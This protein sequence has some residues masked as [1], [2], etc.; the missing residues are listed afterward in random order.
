MGFYYEQSP[1]P[2]DDDDDGERPGCLD[3]LVIIR[4]VFGVLLWPIAAIIIVL[5]DLALIFYFLTTSP[6]L[7]VI[8][9]ALTVLAFILLAR[10]EAAR[11]RPP[12]LGP[13]NPP[14]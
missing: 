9:V 7:A 5:L 4:I 14:S 8:P 2:G 10:W 11:D 6:I 3:T 13:P 1:P 12:D